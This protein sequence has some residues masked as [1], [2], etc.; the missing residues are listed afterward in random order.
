MSIRECAGCGAP[1]PSNTYVCEFC[2]NENIDDSG[3]K[4]ET[5]FDVILTRVGEKTINVIK[6]VRELKNLDLKEAKELTDDVPA[7]LKREVS[8]KRAEEI[9]QI[10][11]GLGASIE[12]KNSATRATVYKTSA[13]A[14]PAKETELTTKKLFLGCPGIVAATLVVIL[15]L[16]IIVAIFD[17]DNLL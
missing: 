5:T 1:L 7:T 15:L 13:S 4:R 17:L 12:I 2:G 8:E 10:F 3:K 9:K 16:G 14:A 6:S 11:E